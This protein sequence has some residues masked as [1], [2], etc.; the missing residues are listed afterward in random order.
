MYGN[1]RGW[2]C[3]DGYAKWHELLVRGGVQL[4]IS[5]HTHSYAFFPANGSAYAQLVGGGP[6]PQAATII[7]AH[8]D[9]RRLQIVM[10]D[11]AGKELLKH[12]TSVSWPE[13]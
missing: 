3:D 2:M 8:A 10:S 6:K 12:E 4:V 1:V 11:L 5:G 7:T 9:G 13:L